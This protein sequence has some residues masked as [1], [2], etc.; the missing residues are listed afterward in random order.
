MSVK[1]IFKKIWAGIK[2]AQPYLDMA[3]SFLPGGAAVSGALHALS[4]IIVRA[5][6][7][8]PSQGSGADK[9]AFFTLEAMKALEATTGKNFDSPEGRALLAEYA[10]VEV[11]V[12][13]AKAEYA[14]VAQKVAA[15]IASVKTPAADDTTETATEAAPALS[16]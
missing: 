4:A 15:Y 7:Q 1:S 12:R 13:N 6:D 3:A 10:N 8:F 16:Y 14:L 2:V 11:M 5:E 9:A